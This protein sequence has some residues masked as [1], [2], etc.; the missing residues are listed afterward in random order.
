MCVIC[1]AFVIPRIYSRNSFVVE[2]MKFD[3][4]DEV[5]AAVALAAKHSR[6]VVFVNCDWAFMSPYRETFDKFAENWHQK[7]PD[8]PVHFHCIDFSTTLDYSSIKSLPGWAETRERI[9]RNP[10][11]G[12]GEYAW[13]LNGRLVDI[14]PEWFATPDELIKK[15]DRLFAETNGN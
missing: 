15:A 12:S 11:G 13:I 5:D 10:F 8:K 4:R 3:S 7:R 1:S 6:S 14:G 9:G 2:S